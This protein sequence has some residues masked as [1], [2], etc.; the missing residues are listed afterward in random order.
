[1]IY[2][3]TKQ[4]MPSKKNRAN[5]LLYRTAETDICSR[6]VRTMTFSIHPMLVCDTPHNRQQR[7]TKYLWVLESTTMPQCGG[8]SQ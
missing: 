7:T 2:F 1:M 5:I 8:D 3:L 4:I 6:M